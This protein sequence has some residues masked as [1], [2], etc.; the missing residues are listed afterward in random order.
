MYKYQTTT[1]KDNVL[2]MLLPDHQ[3]I[4][5]YALTVA[6]YALTNTVYLYHIL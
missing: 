1:L 4:L 2:K 3:R 6:L 5:N